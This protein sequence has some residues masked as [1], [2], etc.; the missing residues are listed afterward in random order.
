MLQILPT[1]PYK[2]TTQE[3][4]IILNATK[5]L[6]YNQEEVWIK[7]K[8]TKIK[9]KFSTVQWKENIEQKCVS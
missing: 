8:I 6:L 3:K 4:N 7:G 9:T 1:K 2:I 5:S